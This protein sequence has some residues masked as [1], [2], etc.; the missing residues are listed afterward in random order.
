MILDYDKCYKWNNADEIT[1]G[2]GM[3]SIATLDE[4]VTWGLS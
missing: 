1:T 4:E 3:G 2:V